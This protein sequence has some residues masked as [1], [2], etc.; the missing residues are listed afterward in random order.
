M[1]LDEISELT[2]HR[3][4]QIWL[5][6]VSHAQLLLRSNR[7]TQWGTRVDVLFKGVKAIELP[8]ILKGLSLVKA[9]RHEA[10]AT[11]EKI[12]VQLHDNEYVFRI[13]GPNYVGFVIAGVAFVHEDE[14]YHY[15]PSFFASSFMPRSDWP[16]WLAY[17]SGAPT[18]GGESQ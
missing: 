12:G 1:P 18:S 3:D 13:R 9:P 6:T 8:T 2:F 15:D 14:G 7:S 17:G 10:L 11:S 5:Y 4:F 16:R